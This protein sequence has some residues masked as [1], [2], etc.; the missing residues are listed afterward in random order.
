M[1]ES[2]R[3]VLVTGAASGIGAAIARRL[4]AAGDRLVLADRDEVGLGA[5]ADELGASAHLVDVSDE[6]SVGALASR[7][8]GLDVLV[9]SAGIATE[10]S[11]DDADLDLYRRT[12]DVNLTGTVV[13][14]R[15]VLPF[16]RES[17]TARVLNIGSVQGL[18]AQAGVYAY[19]TS[20]G[21]VHN[22]TRA[23]AVDLAPDGILVNALAPGFIDTPM[24]VLPDGGTEYE[25]D[26]FASVY[27]EHG[28][29]P[30]RRPGTPDEVA[31]AA[32]FL[33]SASN[34]YITGAVL[35]V[36]GG[37]AATF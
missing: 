25:T 19:A 26:W 30:L 1:S 24:A 6:Q 32:E 14:T 18:Q 13:V 23:L 22:L 31:V 8:D 11:L 36:D 20:K 12:I 15:A 2:P 16:L 27:L 3:T 33:V 7:L 21:G 17:S 4:A 37:L 9:N 5:L 28:R 34:T 29:L 35:P 10:T